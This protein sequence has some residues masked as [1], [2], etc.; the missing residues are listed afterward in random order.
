VI[1]ADTNYAAIKELSK[2]LVK[3]DDFD[4]V[5]VAKSYDD[6]SK[7]LVQVRPDILILDDSLCGRR[8]GQSILKLVGESSD[9]RI[10]V[11]SMYKDRYFIDDL[12]SSGVD[13]YLLKDCAFEELLPA[14]NAIR[15]GRCYV[16]PNAGYK[17]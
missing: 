2:L 5:A 6:I 3:A 14:L 13:G 1:I 16:S 4:I 11:L 9:T 12:F 17:N 10:L 15:E 8:D 7:Q